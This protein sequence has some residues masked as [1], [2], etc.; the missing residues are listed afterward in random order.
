MDMISVIAEC[1]ALESR[2]KVARFGVC[3]G[4]DEGA[5]LDRIERLR[6]VIRSH[7]PASVEEEHAQVMY[8]VNR[9]R[10]DGIGP[11]EKSGDIGIALDLLRRAPSAPAQA[12]SLPRHDAFG[13]SLADFVTFASG[14]MALIDTE[15]R[16]L[17]TSQ[18]NAEFYGHTPGEIMGLHVADLIGASRFE[19]RARRQFERCFSGQV[20]EYHHALDVE[21]DAR[22]M[23]CQMYPAN[24]SEPSRI[25]AVVTMTDVTDSVDAGYRLMPLSN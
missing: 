13:G 17:A 16:Y 9:T 18:G 5:L 11:G 15:F 12:L 23:R 7:V 14:R 20:I 2:L 6:D 4:G 21:G 19:Q 22:I 10:R 8:F 1:L 24:S 3:S 25:G